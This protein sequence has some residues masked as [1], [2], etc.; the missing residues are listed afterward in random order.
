MA[1]LAALEHEAGG[2]ADLERELGRNRGRWR[3]RECRRCRNRTISTQP[4]GRIPRI[5][6]AIYEIVR[7]KPS[8]NVSVRF[9][10]AIN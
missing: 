3:G 4:Q 7:A 5:A 8:K 1:V 9:G 10:P 2:L 6:A